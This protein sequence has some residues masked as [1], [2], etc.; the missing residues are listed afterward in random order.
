MEND[1]FSVAKRYTFLTCQNNYAAACG[2]VEKEKETSLEED[3]AGRAR[4][5][6]YV[7]LV[8]GQ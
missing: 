1:V 3:A 8:S 6:A 7:N 2:N 4:E 5:R